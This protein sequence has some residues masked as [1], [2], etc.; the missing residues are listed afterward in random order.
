MDDKEK[1]LLA[2]D[3][4]EGRVFGTWQMGEAD[5]HLIPS[6]FMPLGLASKE[7]L[8]SMTDD[9]ITQ[10][11][12]YMDKAGPRAINGFPIFFSMH[13]INED[14]WAE[15]RA[16]CEQYKKQKDEFIGELNEASEV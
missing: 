7:V 8:K 6:I 5:N 11:Y 4:V 3:I 2:T 16:M 10:V 13:M 9:K 12:E 14:D 1:K 15:V